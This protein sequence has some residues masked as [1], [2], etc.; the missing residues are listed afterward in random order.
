[1]DVWVQFVV[2]LE[3]LSSTTT[4]PFAPQMKLLPVAVSGKPAGLAPAVTV[5]GLMPVSA[6]GGLRTVKGTDAVEVAPLITV[7]CASPPFVMSAAGIVATNWFAEDDVGVSVK[8]APLTAKLTLD[9]P[10]MK[11]LPF[12]VKFVMSVLL[13]LAVNGD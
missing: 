3:V 10:A 4:V 1:M 8:V 5:V 6:G 9:V 7:T 2:V 12:T 11:P 13:A